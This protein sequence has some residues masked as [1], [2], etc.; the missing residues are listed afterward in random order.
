[1][2][3][4]ASLLGGATDMSK[5]RPLLWSEPS[6]ISRYAIAV[7]AVAIA[8]VVAQLLTVFL[9]TEPIASSMIS[10]VMFAAWFG[11][12]GPGLLAIALAVLAIHYYVVPPLNSFAP[13]G[14]LFSL[15]VA[16]LPRLILFS[17]A[18]LFII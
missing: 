1:M 8:I 3:R 7:L 12:F 10:A 14:N 2:S 16:E 5:P 9:H 4:S 13:K 11:G 18:S 17:I 6:A 15:E